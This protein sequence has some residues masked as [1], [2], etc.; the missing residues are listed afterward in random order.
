MATG[1]YDN[2]SIKG[3][4]FWD[5]AGANGKKVCVLFPHLGFPVWS[6]NGVM[7]GRSTDFYQ[8]GD[9]IQ[10]HPP[11]KDKMFDFTRLYPIKA[12]PKHKLYPRYIDAYRRLITSEAEFGFKLMAENDWDILFTYSSALDWAGHNLWMFFDDKDPAYPGAN[13]YQGVFLEFYKMYDEII[14]DFMERVDSDTT[15]L[16]LSDHGIRMRPYKLVNINEIL[17]QMGLLTLSTEAREVL[18]PNNLLES[19]KRQ[20]ANF[21]NKHGVGPFFMKITHKMPALRKIYTSPKTIHWEKTIAYT[22]DLSGIKA[23]SYGGIIV[24]RALA[25]TRFDEIVDRIIHTLKELKDP[26]SGEA[27]FK[28]I[29]RREELYQGEHVSKYPE[30]VYELRHDYG[31][32][33][34]VNAP[35]FGKTLIHSIQSGSH[36]ADT[37]IF[38]AYNLGG[39]EAERASISLEDIA[40]SILDLLGVKTLAKFDGRSVFKKRLS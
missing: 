16:V 1:G 39:F 40:P 30:I 33:W 8:K 38:Y 37:P 14:G 23:Y 13:Q 35:I 25:G 17:K 29:C 34:A 12:A 4:T 28:W 19:A 10:V 27:I 31:A 20:F 5:I 7:V 26:E 9:P 22:S 21:I 11:E 3:R 15:L 18:N 36:R 2:T 24:V 6:V 32:G